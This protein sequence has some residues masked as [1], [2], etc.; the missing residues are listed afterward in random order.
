M[1]AA[2]ERRLLRELCDVLRQYVLH[3]QLKQRRATAA[4]ATVTA[5]NPVVAAPAALPDH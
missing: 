3:A 1:G 2:V 4:A 5:C